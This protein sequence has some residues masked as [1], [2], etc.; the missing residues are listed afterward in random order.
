MSINTVV[1]Y[2]I[3]P[4]RIPAWEN[5]LADIAKRAHEES[6]PIRYLCAQV[7]GGELSSYDIVLPGE[8][9]SEAATRE[10]APALIARLFN[11]KE[12]ARVMADTSGS[13][14]SAQ[15]TILRDRPELGYPD[16][17]GGGEMAAAVVTTAVVRPGHQEAVEELFRKV[18]E[19]IPKTGDVRRFSTWQPLIGDM[20]AL[21]AVRPVRAFADLDQ[22][23]PIDELLVQAFGPA[24]GGL[25][26]RAAGE[27][28][29][30]LTSQL[31]VLRADLSRVPE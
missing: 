2:R 6:D 20:R 12:A 13:I 16:E 22:I 25:V 15:S 21:H 23:G 7:Q 18:A 4:D 17:A 14:L 9:V 5:A 1:R 30:S 29:E 27:G 11:S 31:M 26:Y 24:E 8:T 10:P 19:A 28:L 3:R